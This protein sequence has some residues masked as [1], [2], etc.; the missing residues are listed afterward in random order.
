LNYEDV[1]HAGDIVDAMPASRL[2]DA[3]VAEIYR[4]FQVA[5]FWMSSADSDQSL[6]LVT[7]D[8]MD[9]RI[10]RDDKWHI[11]ARV[12]E[13]LI[14]PHDDWT[15]AYLGLGELSDQ[16]ASKRIAVPMSAFVHRS[17]SPTWLLDVSTDAE[18]LKQTFE[19]GEWPTEIDRGWIEF[20]HVKYG[21]SAV[22]GVQN[23]GP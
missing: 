5:P 17:Y 3:A 20:T 18:L 1:E 12:R 11:L 6:S 7:V 13:L 15:V 9:G 4:H 22:D 10:I 14:A 8:E 23:S 16:Q 21:R 19:T 2:S